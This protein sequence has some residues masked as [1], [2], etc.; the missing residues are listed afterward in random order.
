VIGLSHLLGMLAAVVIAALVRQVSSSFDLLAW[1]AA[2]MMLG[3]LVLLLRLPE[4]RRHP[5]TQ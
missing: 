5:V 3:S 4:P 1:I 2:G